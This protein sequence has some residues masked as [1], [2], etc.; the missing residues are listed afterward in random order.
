MSGR[1]NQPLTL[2][3]L[4]AA[5]AALAAGLF[6][7]TAA[8]RL[9]YPYDLDFVENGLLL[10]A[11]QHAL[12]RPVYVAPNADFMPNVYMPLYPWLGGGLLTLTGVAYWPLRLLSSAAAL[13]TAGLLGWCAHRE[14]GR[15]WLGI[16][17]AG[18][19]LGGYRL[20]GFWYDLVRVDA[21]SVALAVSGWAVGV[22]AGRT[23]RGQWAAAGLL[24]L[25]GFTKQTAL[26]L[27]VA[28]AG[29]L[30]LQ[31]GRRA[32]H[33]PA[34][35]A[36]G[37]GLAFW[38][39]DTAAGGWFRFHV[40]GVAAGDPVEAGRVIRYLG[41]ELFGGLGALSGL[42]V[43]A[44]AL[45]ARA[46]GARGVAAQPWFIGL[47]AAAVVSGVGRA[48]VGGNLNNLMPVCAFLCLTPALLARAWQPAAP[49]RAE[50][51]IAALVL[52]QLA[53]GAYNP[54]RYIPTPEM[55]AAGDRLITRLRAVD[56]EVLVLMHPYYALL[57]GHTPS[58]QVIHLW[59][60]RAYAGRP[61]PADW[62]ARITERRYAA[63]VS[64]ESVFEMEPE[65]RALLSAHYY[66]AERLSAADAPATLMGMVVRPAVLYRPRAPDQ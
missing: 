28:L 42:G 34:V 24:I 58:A 51:L 37:A 41:L 22:Y 33:F 39:V 44:L 6:L 55:R 30:L 26:A 1:A 4:A 16:A 11:W 3:R 40:L 49:R 36:A 45:T 66:P 59:Y 14:S 48:S 19:Y 52:L 61:W 31:H 13:W 47:A 60:L 10:E 57:A 53:A 5:A 46:G 23:R 32:W 63:I 17:A 35:C 54:A 25:A 27:A 62:T 21:L 43:A 56:G 20:T 29:A 38:G 50:A 65:F 7:L 18:L 2:P 9:T 12:G 8:L 15:P 64:D